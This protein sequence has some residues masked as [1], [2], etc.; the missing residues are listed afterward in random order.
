M[1]GYRRPRV[2]NSVA[3][4]PRG[5]PDHLLEDPPKGIYPV[6]EGPQRCFYFEDRRTVGG[7]SQE[8]GFELPCNG[9]AYPGVD[10]TGAART[11]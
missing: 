4:I 11:S 5:F 2:F 9:T 8:R 7:R 10:G 1:A 6:E 3:E